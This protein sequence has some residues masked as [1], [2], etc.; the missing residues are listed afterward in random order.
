MN[1]L[2]NPLAWLCPA[3]LLLAAGVARAETVVWSDNFDT[4]AASR[5]SA[6]A[7]G[8]WKLS[9]PTAG[10]PVSNGYR[11]HSGADCASSQGYGYS[12][13]AR[14]VCTSYNGAST[15]LVPAANEY[16]RLRFWHWFNFQNALGFVEVSTNNGSTWTQLSPTYLNLNGGGVWSRPWLDL[17]GYSGLNIQIAFHFTSGCCVGNGL[18]WFVD[19]VAVVTDTPVLNFPESFE[20][21]EGDWSVDYGTWEVGKPTSG[22]LAAHTGTNC[23]A[24]VLAG[25]YANNVDSRL[26]SPPFSVPASGSPVLRFWQ[27]VN[28]NNALG[29]VEVNNGSITVTTV[30]NT[31]ITTNSATGLNTNIYQL[32][33]SADEAYSTPLYWNSTIGGWTN[34][35]KALGNVY[36]LEHGGFFFESGY[37]PLS[38]V[39]GVNVDYL[40][41]TNPAPQSASAT[42]FLALNGAV[43]EAVANESDYP[44]GYFASNTVTTYTTNTTVSTGTSSWTQLSPTYKNIT[45][46]WEEVSLDLSNY[47]GQTVY[48]AFHFTSGGVYTAPGWYVDDITLAAPPQLVVPTNQTIFAGDLLDVDVYATNGLPANGEYTF[49]L[50][51]S[52]TNVFLSN[53]EITWQTTPDQPSSTNTIR[54]AVTDTNTPPFSVTNSFVVTVINQGVPTLIVPPTQTI[55]AGQSLSVTVYAT[56]ELGDAFTYSLLSGLTNASANLDESDLASD[57]VLNWNTA[58][59]LKA[60]TYTNVI[61]ATDNDSSYANSVTNRFLVVVSNAIPPTLTVPRQVVYA[62]QQWTLTLYPSSVYGTNSTFAFQLLSAL[63]PGMNESQ[64]ATGGVLS[65]NVP[66][67]QPAKN[68][69]NTIKVV[70]SVSL[71]SATN[72]FVIAI[73]NALP[74][75]LTVPP[76]QKLF[77]GQSL[78]VTNYASSVYGTNSSFTFQLLSAPQT[79]MDLSEF[80]NNGVLSWNV[81]GNQAAK[82]Y[83]NTIE[84]VDSVSQLSATTN[85][86]IV[87]SNPPPPTLSVPASQAIFAGQSLTVTNSATSVYGTNSTLTFALL[88]GLTNAAA[89]LNVSGLTNSG[90]LSWVTTAGLAAGK[91]TNRISV[92]DSVSQ[93]LATNS[94]VITVSNPPPPTL[95]VPAKQ[96]LYA[97]QSLTVTNTATSVYGTN[98]TFTFALLSGLNLPAAGLN[99][100]GLASYGVLT[101]AT[102]TNLPAGSYT[103]KVTVLDSVSQ[104]AATNSFVL[105]IVTN[106]P[107]PPTL[108]VPANQTIYA[109]ASLTVTNLATSV[110]GTNSTFT[111]SLVSSLTNPAA[112]LNVM[113]LTN[114]GIVSWATKSTLTPATYTNIVTV[115][116]NLSLLSATNSFLV[117][118]LPPQPPTLTVPPTQLIFAGQLM[119]VTNTAT[120][121]YAN[122][123][124]TFLASGPTNLDVSNLAQNGVL[125]WTPIS[126]Q[127]PGIVTIWVQVTDSRALGALTNFEVQVLVPPS[128]QWSVSPGSKT[129]AANVFQF[130]LSAQPNSTWNIEAT[131]NL[132]TPVANWLPLYTGMSDSGGSLLFTDL[133]A[134]NFPQRYYRAV[135]P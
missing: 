84:V 5:W 80:A 117:Q 27:W 4:N 79:G 75:K 68:Y 25:N 78:T 93:G 101:W 37:A 2:R 123:T 57:G 29:F 99:V 6:S 55:Y 10:P 87:V 122:D 8:V 39:G 60:G 111:F 67:N 121:V 89:G 45:S 113:Q 102:K 133:L 61:V 38:A 40:A 43:W 64:L 105:V 108:S 132:N 109:G 88:S 114:D 100:S 116:D 124:F 1:R 28:F 47:V 18:G 50:L 91:Y 77:A 63:P 104:L 107:P 71:L 128:P 52:P 86:V 98:S 74:P 3:L 134:T 95:V 21:G 130:T 49:R 20:A 82:N 97:G 12:K 103:N 41:E 76:T 69:T 110:F 59:A 35:T 58:A 17:S 129:S 19:D 90:V 9:S 65:W 14:L 16:P 120:S 135:L 46:G 81:P 48:I 24:T 44:I 96:A 30:T 125:K 13:D 118:V 94:F 36:D 34:A 56:N 15:L 53:G 7:T 70:D 131:T 127:A 26:I 42:N 66:T 115:S 126:S 11:T 119:V 31:V 22:P 73:S 92:L 106:S 83:T 32:F 23:A 62:G 72:S 51:S 112:G 54:V 33:G 85:F